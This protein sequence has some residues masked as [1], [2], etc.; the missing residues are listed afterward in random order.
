MK[1]ELSP[2]EAQAEII[3]RAELDPS[4]VTVA[5][6][7]ATLPLAITLHTGNK[8]LRYWVWRDNGSLRL[9]DFTS[10]RVGAAG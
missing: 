7:S 9:A 4:S 8:P 6:R 1:R 3:R 2:T 10:T 5:S